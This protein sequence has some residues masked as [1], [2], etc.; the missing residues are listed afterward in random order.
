MEPIIKI[1]NLSKTYFIRTNKNLFTGLFNPKNKKIKAVDN[2]SFNVKEGESIAFL[3]PN[4]AGK[5]TTI[6]MLTGLIF[7][8]SGS[9]SVLGY[10]PFDKKIPFL[11]Q[12]GLV[13]GN[14][15]GL[16]WDLTPKQ[17]F[18]LLQKV[19]DI[20][21]KEYKTRLDELTNILN[22]QSVLDTPIRKLSLGERMKCELI[23]SILHNPKILFLDEPTI[24]LDIISKKKIRIFLKDLQ[25]KYHT[26]IVL[27]SHDMDDIQFVCDRVVIINNGKKI[28]DND[29][30]FLINSYNKN[31]IIKFYFEGLF[32][33]NINM[34]YANIYTKDEET[35]TFKV[36]K[37]LMPK[38]I[39]DM[40]SLY[41]IID[42]DILTIPLE[43][44]IEDIFNKTTYN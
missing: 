27:T 23:G 37:E 14:K 35:I 42:I 13:M 7:P 28:Y 16:A 6:K 4:G 29:L 44:V 18:I 9:V 1:N 19:Y 36:K 31:K 25:R 10:I 2:I 32:P 17:N 39:S 34:P 5:T 33:K 41:N 3:G 26:T 22:V 40:A 20:D 15:S 24:G 8:T 30:T 12:I 38:L 21:T 43:N 11:K